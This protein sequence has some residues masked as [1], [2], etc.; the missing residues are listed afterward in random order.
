NDFFIFE[1]TVFNTYNQPLPLSPFSYKMY[2]I[3]QDNKRYRPIKYDVSLDTAVP[4]GGT[5][6][7]FVYFPKYDIQSN[8]NISSNKIRISIE[9]IGPI[10]QE[11]VEF[12]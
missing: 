5:V 2:L 8:T 4:P 3:G 11:I 1:V 7:G 6:T 9:E 10:K 12:R